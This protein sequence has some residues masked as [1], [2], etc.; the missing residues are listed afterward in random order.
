LKKIFERT[1]FISRQAGFPAA[2]YSRALRLLEI[3]QKSRLACRVLLTSKSFLHKCSAQRGRKQT[4]KDQHWSVES[5]Y[6]NGSEVASQTF[7]SQTFASQTRAFDAQ[8][9]FTRL[10]QTLV[11]PTLAAS[12]RML[13]NCAAAV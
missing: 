9:F 12:S 10:L 11:A 13:L 7:A 6:S 2:Y 5:S 8:G 3:N 1:P 4:L